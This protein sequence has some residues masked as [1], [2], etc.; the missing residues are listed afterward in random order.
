MSQPELTVI[1][2][3]HEHGRFLGT[4]L[5][6]L[7][8]ERAHI[9]LEVIVVDNASED[10]TGA[11]V[12]RFPWVRILRNDRRRGFAFNNNRA[13]RVAEGRHVF[14]LNPDTEVVAGALQT[15]VRHLDEH[16]EVGI[17]GPQL[18]FPD[19]S[20]QLSARRFPTL[21]WVLLRR[22]PLRLVIPDAEATRRHLMEEVDH[23][24]PREVDWL[25]GAALLVRREVL[26]TVGLLDEGYFLYVEDIDWAY[27][28][29]RAGWRVTYVPD[30]RVVHHYQADAD[31]RLLSR[32][33]WIH[34]QGM[35]RFYR[36]HLAPRWLRARVE[37]ELL[38]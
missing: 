38:G 5:D 19:G 1:T 9:A 16:P 27:R 31:R 32:Y 36:K 10:D 11:V 3:S 35:W 7:Q 12:A 4:L 29:H 23:S 20:L 25:L 21:A 6:S 24:Q 30:A 17:C 33:S 18:R 37:P 14:L 22:T 8:R 13:I 34:L 2:V 15:L 26:R 28:A